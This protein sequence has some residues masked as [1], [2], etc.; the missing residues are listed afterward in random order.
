M[1]SNSIFGT[2]TNMVFF[3]IYGNDNVKYTLEFSFSRQDIVLLMN[4]V[5]VKRF[6]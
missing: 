6:Q 1:K 5:V 4:D 2:Y 3:D